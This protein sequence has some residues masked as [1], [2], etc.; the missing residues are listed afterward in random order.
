MK[1]SLLF[2]WPFLILG[3]LLLL[4]IGNGIIKAYTAEGEPTGYVCRPSIM[5]N[6]RIYLMTSGRYIGEPEK[7]TLECVGVLTQAVEQCTQ[8]TENLQSCGCE[9]LVGGNIYICEQY[10]DYLFLYNEDDIL[11]PFVL[12]SAV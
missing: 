4:L 1:R 7:E 6:D 8:L 3:A 5:Y 11:V 9:Y 12:E 2:L 10:P